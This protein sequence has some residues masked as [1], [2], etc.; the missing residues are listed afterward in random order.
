MRIFLAALLLV[1]PGH[2]DIC[3]ITLAWLVEQKSSPEIARLNTIAIQQVNEMLGDLSPSQR[4]TMV[5]KLG[6]NLFTLATDEGNGAVEMGAHHPLTLKPE[7]ASLMI[8]HPF[9]RV[10]LVHEIRHLKDM[11]ARGFP[12]R[13]RELADRML[14]RDWVEHHE[15]GPRRS[16]YQYLR[17]AYTLED[18]AKMNE[19]AA[20]EDQELAQ[21]TTRRES[22][23]RQMSA[24]E[25]ARLY[26]LLG[27]R[28]LR[29]RLESAL[30]VSEDAYVRAP[31]ARG[32]YRDSNASMNDEQEAMRWLLI[33]S[34]AMGI[35]AYTFSSL[36]QTP[37]PTPKP[38]KP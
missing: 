29:L 33:G 3:D 32:N 20:L 25:T 8:D 31:L 5:A 10:L 9:G 17:K 14:S 23:H 19:K 37:S 34:A 26:Y 1:L 2:A 36:D 21:L 22:S 30:H 4:N 18:L 15:E 6:E 12:V 11:L 38:P 16:E 7:V 35:G 27:N 13:A 24:Q 28:G